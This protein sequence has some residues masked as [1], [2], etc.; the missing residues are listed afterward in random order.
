M[1]IADTIHGERV[2]GHRP[3]PRVI[4]RRDGWH[5]AGQQLAEG[6]WTL[7]GLW[8]DAGAVHMSILADAIGAIAVITLECPDGRYPSIGALHPPAEGNRQDLPGCFCRH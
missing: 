8:G 6:H 1:T 7:L 3:W 5:F 2:P 4:V